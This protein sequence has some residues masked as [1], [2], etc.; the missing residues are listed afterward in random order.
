MISYSYLLINKF[1]SKLR[2]IDILCSNI[3]KYDPC[4]NNKNN[5]RPITLVHIITKVFEMFILDYYADNSMIEDLQF[6][7]K[8]RIGRADATLE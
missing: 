5:Y 4:Y 8:T 1:Y 2:N 7:L 6:D 3:C